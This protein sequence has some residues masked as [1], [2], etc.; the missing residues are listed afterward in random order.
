MVIE[1]TVQFGN[2]SANLSCIRKQT[3]VRGSLTTAPFP[4]TSD[5]FSTTPTGSSLLSYRTEL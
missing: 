2:R 5:A 4:S 1:M 3:M